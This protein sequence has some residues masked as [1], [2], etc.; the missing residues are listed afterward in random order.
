VSN[1]DWVTVKKA[2]AITGLPSTFF[3]ERTGASGVWPEGTVWKW[4]EGRK[5]VNLEAVY[6]VID[7]APS[8][9]SNRGRRREPA[10]DECPAHQK[11]QPA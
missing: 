7:A 11:T 5:L 6:D 1:R 10:N 3:D 2:E 8:I 4:F 9:A